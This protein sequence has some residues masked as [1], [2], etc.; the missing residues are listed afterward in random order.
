MTE[1]EQ[2]MAQIPITTHDIGR[3]IETKVG[4]LVVIEL[5]ENPTTGFLSNE[6]PG[7]T[8]VTDLRSSSFRPSQDE[9]QP[10]P[11]AV[12]AGAPG[13]ATW[14]ARSLAVERAD[15]DSVAGRSGKERAPSSTRSPLSFP[16]TTER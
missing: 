10:D 14:N 16:P 1:R 11:G 7:S 8:G 3:T 15:C 13:R 9:T 12:V 5:R 6:E 2:G 4:D